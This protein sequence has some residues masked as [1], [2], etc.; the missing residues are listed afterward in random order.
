LAVHTD[1]SL[2]L[3]ESRAA[4]LTDVRPKIG[5]SLFASLNNLYKG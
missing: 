3:G 4:R 1:G 2:S 5:G